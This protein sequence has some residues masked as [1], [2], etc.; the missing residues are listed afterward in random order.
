[1]KKK[2]FR[3]FYNSVK[4]ILFFWKRLYKFITHILIFTVSENFHYTN[5][6]YVKTWIQTLLFESNNMCA[7]DRLLNE[8]AIVDEPNT[9]ICSKFVNQFHILKKKHKS[10]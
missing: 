2:T 5:K 8:S 3:E 7:H 6:I 1:M 10:Q 4:L 9:N